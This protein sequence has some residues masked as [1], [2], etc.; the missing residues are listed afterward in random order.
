MPGTR[1]PTNPAS[2]ISKARLKPKI[3]IVVMA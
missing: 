2:I 3:S 1:L